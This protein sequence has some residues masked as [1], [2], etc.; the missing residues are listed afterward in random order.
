[1]LVRCK[2]NCTS[3]SFHYEYGTAMTPMRAK[4]YPVRANDDNDES[5]QFFRWTP[6]G[7]INTRSAAGPGAPVVVPGTGVPDP[8]LKMGGVYYAD[9]ELNPDGPKR[10]DG[11]GRLLTCVH[12]VAYGAGEGSD[13]VDRL[14]K[15][16]GG[17]I[18]G[19]LHI[20]NPPAADQFRPGQWYLVRFTP[21]AE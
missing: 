10:P 1:M 6:S 11:D 2:L 17:E 12:S 18:S 4:L 16:E 20:T 19:H 13:S 15:F 9:F 21:A 14:V 5:N 3:V 7:E 8:G